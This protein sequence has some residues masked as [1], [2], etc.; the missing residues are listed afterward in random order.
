MLVCLRQFKSCTLVVISAVSFAQWSC[1]CRGHPFCILVG[2]HRLSRAPSPS[3]GPPPAQT[4]QP[5]CTT[6]KCVPPRAST[7]VQGRDLASRKRQLCLEMTLCLSPR[8][9]QETHPSDKESR[10]PHSLWPALS[11]KKLWFA[12]LFSLS[13][14]RGPLL[15]L[16]GHQ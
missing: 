11:C 14:A 5:P 1:G 3:A 12:H 4:C 15:S 2:G 8:V 7:W 13:G 16:L 9:R 10:S 6:R